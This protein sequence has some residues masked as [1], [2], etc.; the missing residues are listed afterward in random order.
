[1][2]NSRTPNSFKLRLKV[3]CGSLL[4]YRTW[5]AYQSECRGVSIV[6]VTNAAKIGDNTGGINYLPPNT[7]DLSGERARA[8][9]DRRHRFEMLGTINPGK[10]FN[11]GVS[12]SLYSGLPY[13]LTAGLDEFHTGTAN[14]RPAGVPRNSRQ[15]SGYADVDL[16]WS[17]DFFRSRG[18]RRTKA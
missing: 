8:D 16:R 2:R 13:T 5:A 6:A 10:L 17:R 12:L 18:R 15:G 9:F 11:L 14:A 3:Y 7:Y 1:V 4:T